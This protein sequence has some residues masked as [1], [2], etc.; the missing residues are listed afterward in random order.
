ME[1]SKLCW[2]IILFNLSG[3]NSKEKVISLAVKATLNGS[4]EIPVFPLKDSLDLGNPKALGGNNFN[5]S[6]GIA[7]LLASI[8][9][10]T[11]TK[12]LFCVAKSKSLTISWPSPLAA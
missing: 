1:L 8:D 7:R 3:L 9:L 4:K 2:T 5:L 12:A 6:L 11:Y 10:S